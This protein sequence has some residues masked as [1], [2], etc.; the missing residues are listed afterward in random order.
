MIISHGQDELIFL[1]GETFKVQKKI[2]FKEPAGVR[3]FASDK[4]GGIYAG[5]NKGIFKI[6]TEGNILQQW[7]KTTGLPDE[8]VYAI[9]FDKEGSLWCSTNKGIIR[10]DK[11]NNL[12]QLTKQDGLQENEFNSNVVVVAE[13]GEFYFGGVNG[14]SSFYPSAI[15][16]FNEKVQVLLIGLKVN[17]ENTYKDRAVYNIDKINL[18]FGQ[19]SLSF[20]FVA[21]GDYNPGQYIYQYRM[22]EIDKE[23]IQNNGLQ[24]V[25]YSL[26][27]GKYI[28]QLYA[29]RQFDKN[30]TP[31]KELVIVINPPFWKTWWFRLSLGI[32]VISLLYFIIN[33]RNK[34]KY[35]AQLQQLE[36]ER[37]IKSERERI[38][39][40]LHDSLGAYANAVLYNAELLEKESVDEK[41]NVL[42]SDLKFASKDII[43][44]LRET[45]WALNKEKYT[46]EECLVRI[47][48]FVQPLTRYYSNIN[49]HIEGDA[50]SDMELHYVRA[51]NA[52]RI[53]QEAV[54][55][56]IK[57]SKSKNITIVSTSADNNKWN[58]T[59][60]D[61]GIGFNI[62][63]LKDTA[64]GNGLN[65][66]EQR[67]VAAGFIYTIE[68]K[69]NE[70]TI[71]TIII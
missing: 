43:T 49:F 39:K 33:Q 65:N 42:V 27:P 40:D 34:A 62:A 24:T 41:R 14:V 16:S 59:V 38:S 69:E 28:F 29:S 1:D 7:N 20:D 6:D 32:A 55:N 50:P 64:R 17:N 58:I 30:A 36:N 37:K 19:N 22:K 56:S 68:T 51:L 18:P 35:A 45:V 71:I 31:M 2:P 66:M 63:S 54:A 5:S 53:V 26:S 15:S 48:N 60:S 21:M 12:L 70:G 10:I 47:R 4:D 25:R 44:S 9:T 67:A 3:C 13:D 57:H 23:W 52:V 61:D 11:D 8:C 46:A